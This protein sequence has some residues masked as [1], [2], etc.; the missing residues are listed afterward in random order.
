MSLNLNLMLGGSEVGAVMS[1]A[2][3]AAA[4]PS[5]LLLLLFAACW[6]LVPTSL[7]RVSH[8]R[9]HPKQASRRGREE[10]EKLLAEFE[11]RRK[12]RAAVVPTDDA[13]VRAMLRQLSEPVTLFG[14]REVRGGYSGCFCVVLFLPLHN[15]LRWSPRLTANLGTTKNE[16][17]HAR[18]SAAT[19]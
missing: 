11:L 10:Q 16:Q 7:H 17:Q 2:Q 6:L 19:A 12:I 1:R 9:K 8:C 14:E 4:A 5:T 15:A 13:K 3:R 18:W